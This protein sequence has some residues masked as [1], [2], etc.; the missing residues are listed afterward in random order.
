MLIYS[1]NISNQFLTGYQRRILLDSLRLHKFAQLHAESI[2]YPPLQISR[3][4][5]HGT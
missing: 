1:K 4:Q 5:A 2:C 3:I